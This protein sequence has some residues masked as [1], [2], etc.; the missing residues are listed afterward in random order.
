MK[1]LLLFIAALF[2][3]VASFGQNLV[4]NGDFEE[5]DDD[6]TPTDWTHVE[7]IT[8]ES[9]IVHGGTYSAKHV[10]GTKDLGQNIS[11]EAGKTYVFS[12]WYYVESGDGAD[13]RLWC[14]LADSEGNNDYDNTPDA[15]RGPGGSSGYLDNG[16]GN[17]W[18]NYSATVTIP[19]GL[20][21]LY[22]E[23]RTYSGATV[24]Y[25]DLSIT[26]YVADE[27]TVATPSFSVSTGNYTEEQAVTISSST[28]G[29]TIYYTTDGTEPTT[30]SDVYSSAISVSS[31]T[32]LSALA[33]KTDMTN[34]SVAT[35]TY[36][37]PVVCSDISEVLALDN[38]TFVTVTGEVTEVSVDDGY[39]TV[40]YLMIEDDND[41]Q[42][43]IYGVYNLTETIY[44]VGQ[45]LT[46]TGNRT[47]YSDEDEIALYS[48]SGHSIVVV[49][50]GTTTGISTLEEDAVSVYPNPFA[51]QLTVTGSE[52][53]Q[54]VAII[55]TVGQVVK[56][57][58]VG[59][60]SIEIPTSVL[61][62]G[63]Y[64]VKVTY[65]DGSSQITKVI[66]K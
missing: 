2:I 27:S 66:K 11:V 59:A 18:V 30:S 21:Q 33:V 9:T 64:L 61:A 1:Q 49:S 12:L 23:L 51:A 45:T 58:T 55:N 19:D 48:G 3:S 16:N 34:S 13:A 57:M 15:I 47:E 38:G 5:W 36:T 60:S 39:G 17:E 50:D 32:T 35:A 65:V 53:I 40:T 43:K 7:S 54:T 42:L 6:S 41:V 26:E 37:F 20:T 29:A 56:Q 46:I 24:Y 25:D 4:A 63:V 62:P 44:T 31:T 22:Y 28:E 14:V 52:E 10:G 8:K